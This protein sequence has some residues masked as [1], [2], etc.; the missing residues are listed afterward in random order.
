MREARQTAGPGKKRIGLALAS[1]HTGSGR[2][3][4]STF[5]REAAGDLNLF[6][7]PGGVLNSPSDLE[8][9]R[10]PIYS[11]LNPRNIDGL[12]VWSSS[13]GDTVSPG[14]F[15]D[16]HRSFES[17]PYI[18]IAH[19]IPGR[20]CVKFDAYRG[21]KDLVGH[22]IASHQAR[23]IAFLRGPLGHL[24]SQERFQ[25]Y[26]DALAEAGIPRDE[27]LVSDPVDWTMGAAACAQLVDSRRLLPGRDFDTLIGSSDLMI[28]P[29]VQYISR[30]G[31]QVPADYRVGGFN[32][33]IEGKVLSP[34]LTTV[35]LPY[36]GLVG[37]SFR[38]LRELFSGKFRDKDGWEDSRDADLS[39]RVIIRGSCGCPARNFPSLEEGEID[40]VSAPLIRALRESP[41]PAFFDLFQK[42]FTA[43]LDSGGDAG[44]FLE[45]IQRLRAAPEAAG[46][47]GLVNEL[48]GIVAQAQ[49]HS[50]TYSQYQLE[51]RHTALNSL[52]CEL[53]GTR[54]RR[55]LIE[56]LARHLPGIGIMTASVVLSEDH[57]MSEY[58][59]GFSPEGIVAGEGRRF[60][61]ERLLPPEL[62]GQYSRGIF[63]VQPLFIENRFLGHF[64]HN[65]PFYDGVI[66]EEL[67]STISNALKGI[68]LFEEA[69]RA[70]QI[71]ERAERAKTEFLAAIG[72]SLYDPFAE[73]IDRMGGL[74]SWLGGAKSGLGSGPEAAGL[75]ERI[76]ALKSLAILRQERTNY[77]MELSLSQIDELSFKKSLFHIADLLPE[78]GPG[79]FPLLAGDTARL[80][81]AFALIREIYGDGVSANPRPGGLE[82]NF[83]TRTPPETSS[84][85]TLFLT[86]R[87]VLLHQGELAWNTG[88]CSVLL[89]WIT[90]S[91]QDA[92]RATKERNRYILALSPL[93]VNL[94]AV[95][96]LPLV[97]NLEKAS[98][99]PAQAAFIAWDADAEGWE[100]FEK[101]AALSS[102]PDFFHTPFLCFARSLWGETLSAAVEA[103][104][105]GEKNRAVLFIGVG[106]KLFSSWVEP[107]RRLHIASASEL[108]GA[109]ARVLPS[110]IVLGSID[111]EAISAIRSHPA[112]AMI[113]LIVVPQRMGSPREVT[114]L[115]R[116][117]RVVLCHRSVANSAEFCLRARA[118]AAG[119]DI[120]P[121]YTG[122]LVKKALLYFD[123]HAKS[124]ISRWKL[125]DTVNVSEDYL[126]R[127]FHRE[128]GCS[129][130]E[131][132]NL[133]RVYLAADLLTR[134]GDTISEIAARTGF[135]DQA[136]FCR[137]FKKIYGKTPGQ[138]R[139][140]K[141]APPPV[142][143]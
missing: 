109:A 51:K 80:R 135:Q 49:E 1:I 24:S 57:R 5:A 127:I 84:R 123:E 128:M 143:R 106:E 136:Y 96:G 102:L 61:A 92:A 105:R 4:W 81:D 117:P 47:A 21:M 116:F 13:I 138:L 66:L 98:A 45:V 7:F 130:W 85:H 82:I 31:Y 3:V 14:E 77:L 104:I 79:P 100:G 97:R 36:A 35:H 93:P 32:D 48:F 119:D 62:E 124:H 44:S 28:P 110:L 54:D 125:A 72:N 99:A 39:C 27:N 139:S 26:R 30:L 113:P 87:I 121:I 12:V 56:S 114:E 19:K 18:T 137:V 60:P 11:L 112:T 64:V 89:P 107:D 141:K 10:N 129:L 108:A 118:I 133:Y 8:Y 43:F 86:E 126:T 73:I 2:N 70:K 94:G 91:G 38:I 95:F 74:E 22:F 41:G 131:Y 37:E 75:E 83:S 67:R 33:T 115:S 76:G 63:L 132:L 78:L 29:A 122:T 120:L 9:L 140:A 34:P 46:S 40:S 65:V 71:A 142:E 20:P 25:G 69:Y 42:T 23:K 111:I 134:T 52:K 101:V 55:A 16:F 88:G 15:L 53:L 6:I 90:Y 58:A 68:F 17:L 103:R 59:G 50:Y